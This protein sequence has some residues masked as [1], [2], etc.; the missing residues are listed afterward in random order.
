MSNWI[1][2]Q[3]GEQLIREEKAMIL[4]SKLRGFGGRLA[5]TDRRLVFVRN[6][7]HMFGLLGMLMK[8]KVAFDQPRAALQVTRGSHGRAKEVLAVR[9]NDAEVKFV[10]QTPYAEWEQA[11]LGRRE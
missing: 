5:L 9:G 8:G 6:R 7:A 2:L 3:E 11:L 1:P 4:H 10:L